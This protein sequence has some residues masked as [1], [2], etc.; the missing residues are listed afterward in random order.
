MEPL[1]RPVLTLFWFSDSNLVQFSH[2]IRG[3]GSVD[4]LEG[5]AQ[6]LK[7]QKARMREARTLDRDLS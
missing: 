3:T 5:Q 6:S 7:G 4:N 2:G 1:P